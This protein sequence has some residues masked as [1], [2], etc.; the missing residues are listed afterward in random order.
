VPGGHCDPG[1]P[2]EHACVREVA[3][4]TGLDVAVLRWVGRVE[5]D[6]PAGVTYD[7]DDFV[8]AMLGGELGAADDAAAVRWVCR[9]EFD[10]LP[11]APLLAETLRE[12]DC[13]PRR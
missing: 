5:R 3:E 8:C 10:R 7:I 6:G 4:E 2:A 13:L 1:E 12:W 9:A 11:L